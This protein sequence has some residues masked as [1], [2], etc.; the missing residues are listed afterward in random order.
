MMHDAIGVKQGSVMG[1]KWS[2]QTSC[3]R[4]AKH[5][6]QELFESKRNLFLSQVRARDEFRAAG[7]MLYRD[8]RKQPKETFKLGG[9]NK[10][11]LGMI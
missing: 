2:S 1:T 10:A 7:E 4:R 5:K 11:I 9:S 3:E 8:S 6:K